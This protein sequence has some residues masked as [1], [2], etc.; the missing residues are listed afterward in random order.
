MTNTKLFTSGFQRWQFL[1]FLDFRSFSWQFFL[2]T[3]RFHYWIQE[4]PQATWPPDLESP[5][6]NL[7]AKEWILGSSFYIFF[8]KILSLASLSMNIIFLS[9]S[10]GPTMFIISFHICA[11]VYI[12]WTQA[13]AHLICKDWSKVSLHTLHK[14][15]WKLIN[16]FYVKLFWN[17]YKKVLGIV[18]RYIFW[19]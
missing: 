13:I 2:S 5:V 6:Y 9:H 17:F 10:T 19:N 18:G 16:I 4:G 8:K 12:I 11:Y 7:K 15:I 1:S 14:N 3:H